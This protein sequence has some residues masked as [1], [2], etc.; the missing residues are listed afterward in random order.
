MLAMT[1]R[2][3]G[4][5]MERAM[6]THLWSHFGDL[7]L[8]WGVEAALWDADGGSPADPTIFRGLGLMV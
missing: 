8:L 7:V 3:N 6:T 5:A 4:M 1:S 2:S